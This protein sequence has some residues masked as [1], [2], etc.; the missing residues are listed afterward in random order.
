MYQH[1]QYALFI[2]FVLVWIGGFVALAWNLIG[3]DGPLMVFAGILVLVGFLFHGLTVKVNDTHISW[4]FG[5]GVAGQSIALADIAEAK[6][7][8]NS[9]RHGIGIRITHDGW[10]YTVSGFS[11]IQL[12]LKDGTL[13]RVG[14]ND[15]QG[16]LT[17]LEGKTCRNT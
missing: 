4:A 7:V 15:Q 16:L 1:K 14:T 6:A 13:Y 9:Y 12:T 5:P 17:A 3:A 10:I 8:Q 2:F 11:A